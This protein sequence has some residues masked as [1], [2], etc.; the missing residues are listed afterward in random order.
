MQLKL[1]VHTF[2]P[3]ED[4]VVHHARVVQPL[5]VA[6]ESVSHTA[7]VKQSVPLTIVASHPRDLEPQHQAGVAEPDL[8]RQP[9]EPRAVGRPVGRDPQVVVD[10]HNPLAGETKLDRALHQRVLARG[11]LDVVQNAPLRGLAG[12]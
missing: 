11:R 1:A 7:Q 2:H 12:R 6:D 10:H 3:Q 8:R 4:P 5:K 9:G